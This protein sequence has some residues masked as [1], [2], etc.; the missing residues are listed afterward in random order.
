LRSAIAAGP[1]GAAS[2]LEALHVEAAAREDQGPAS[3]A[4]LL[5]DGQLRHPLLIAMT[6]AL[7]IPLSGVDIVLCYSCLVL[8]HAGLTSPQWATVGIG[9]FYAAATLGGLLLVK[10]MRLRALLLS[11][12]A[13][14]ALS[15]AVLA[16][17]TIRSQHL[18]MEHPSQAFCSWLAIGAQLGVVGAFAVGPGA[19]GW[20]AVAEMLPMQSKDAGMALGVSASWTAST[21]VAWGFPVWRQALGALIFIAFSASSAVF[22]AFTYFWVPDIKA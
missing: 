19:I 13:V 8:R 12:W 22:C 17:V 21:L 14:L 15:Y 5:R 11:S 3:I 2:H 4:E 9:I 6:T 16:A 10:T 20:F 1:Q 7:S 18:S